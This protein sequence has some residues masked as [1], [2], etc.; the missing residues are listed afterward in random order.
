M[1]W[2][3][4]F[5]Q[6]WALSDTDQRLEQTAALVASFIAEAVKSGRIILGEIYLPDADKTIKIASVGGIAGGEKFI[7]GGILFKVAEDPPIDA[8]DAGNESGDGAGGEVG[9]YAYAVRAGG[10]V[11]NAEGEAKYGRAG[12]ESK[13]AAYAVRAGGEAAGAQREVKYAAY[14]VGAGG[15]DDDSAGDKESDGQEGPR[16]LY[17]GSTPNAGLAAKGASNELRASNV[18]FRVFFKLGVGVSV[19][20]QVVLDGFGYRLVAMP[21]FMDLKGGKL[22]YGSADAGRTVHASDPEFNG[23]MERAA[24]ELHLA[25]HEVGDEGCS[26]HLFAAGDVEGHRGVK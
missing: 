14:A 18:Y 21:L 4:K 24:K 12:G 8:G 10:E 3:A 2:Q 5:E 1:D 6:A 7:H 15:K 25:G 13:Y 9:G 19:P 20:V 11:A 23:F 22:I 26:Q 16:Y 17:G